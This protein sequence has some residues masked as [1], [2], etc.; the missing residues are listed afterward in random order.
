MTTVKF[1]SYC[2]NGVLKSLENYKSGKLDGLVTYYRKDDPLRN[3]GTTKKEKF[4]TEN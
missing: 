1:K 4:Q 3:L 2:K